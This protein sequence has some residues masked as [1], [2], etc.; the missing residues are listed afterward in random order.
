MR[1]YLPQRFCRRPIGVSG[2]GQAAYHC[3]R[4]HGI[5]GNAAHDLYI[6]PFAKVGD[7][8]GTG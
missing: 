8:A 2:Y 4:H 6:P 7:L 5:V 1:P 3:V